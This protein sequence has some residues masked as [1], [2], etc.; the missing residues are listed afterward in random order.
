MRSGPPGNG[1]VNRLKTLRLRNLSYYEMLYIIS[2][3][4]LM[5][6]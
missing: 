5:V 1:L 6:L 2:H 4:M 3:N